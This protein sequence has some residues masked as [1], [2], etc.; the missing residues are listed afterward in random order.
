MPVITLTTDMGN[1]GYYVASVKAA[2]VK[3]LPDANIIDITH[4]IRPF[5]ITSAAFIIR[6]VYN[7]FPEGTIHIVAVDA[8]NSPNSKVIAIK[9]EGHYFIGPDNGLFSL[10]FSIPPGEVFEITIPT[11]SNS[12]AFI[13]KDIMAK[14]A[15]HIA[16][17]ANL[18]EIGRDYKN[19]T[20][21]TAWQPIYNDATIRTSVVYVDEYGNCI[22]NLEKDLFER[23]GRG[24]KFSVDV[25]RNPVEAISKTYNDVSGGELVALFTGSGL[26]EI[27]INRGNISELL[28][29]KEGDS[30]LISFD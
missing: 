8:L 4:S 20:Q 1:S 23:V 27:A 5:H 10:V 12:L 25:K 3:G 28:G 11:D 15:I 29:L 6:N 9:T 18:N 22:F 14:A 24:R 16:K 17:G 13:A 30:V 7:Q 21:L 2:I 19:Y 26:L